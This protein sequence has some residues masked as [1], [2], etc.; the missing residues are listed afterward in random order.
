[1]DFTSRQNEAR[2]LLSGP[3]RH[4]LLVGGSRSGKTTLL[5]NRV[6]LRALKAPVSRHAILRFRSNAARSSISLDTLPKVFR[7]CF[8]DIRLTE[9]RQDG[10]FELPNSSQIWVGGLD[11][12][13]RVEKILGNEYATMLFN[14]CSQIPYSSVVTARTRLAQVVGNLKQRAYYDLNPGGKSHWT[15]AEFGPQHI[16]PVSRKPLSN[17]HDF[18]RMFMNPVDNLPNLSPEYL[19]SLAHLPARHRARFYEGIYTDE[20]DNAFWSL[21]AIDRA[22]CVMSEDGKPL[23]VPMMRRVV[24]AIDPSGAGAKNENKRNDDIGIVVGGLGFDNRVYLLADVTCN[25]PPEVWGRTAIAA[26]HK[27]GADRIV[28]EV[29]FGGDMVSYVIRS[30]DPGIAVQVLTASRG[31]AVRAEPVSVLYE[32]KQDKA[33]HAGYFPELEDQLVNF[34]PAGYGGERSPDRADAWVWA[35]TDLVLSSNAEGWIT[36]YKELVEGGSKPIEA[37]TDNRPWAQ[38]IEPKPTED[39]LMDVYRATLAELMPG[40]KTCATCNKPLGS[41]RRTDGVHSW[42]VECAPP[43]PELVR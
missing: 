40:A 30:L 16:D 4:T 37:K 43:K 23:D 31:K 2:E 26:Y 41:S 12:K 42:H 35:V 27:W 10:F 34:S 14:E 20:L 11:D 24:V 29:N 18:A 5:V 1:M 21:E 13:D 32:E 7:L 25:G 6:G 17:P 39:N 9:H 15:N 3:Q 36:Y 38:A 33:R 8:P 22:R 19:D 28:A